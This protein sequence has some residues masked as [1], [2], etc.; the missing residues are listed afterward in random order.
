MVV[1]PRQVGPSRWYFFLAIPGVLIGFVLFSFFLHQGTRNIADRLSQVVVPGDA[2]FNFREL[3]TYTIFLEQPS[4]VKGKVYAATA[5]ADHLKCWVTKQPPSQTFVP[6][7]QTVVT[8]RRPSITLSYSFGDRAGRSVLEFQAD[9]AATYRLSCRYPEGESGPV[10]VLAVGRGVGMQILGTLYR[11]FL[12]LL[13]GVALAGIVVI[14]IH[15]KRDE[16]RRTAS[17]TYSE[18]GVGHQRHLRHLRNVV[19]TDD[20]RAI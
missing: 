4:E 2:T 10:V 11:T 3:G 1:Q 20:V 16:S 19:D 9:A 17:L 15:R 14:V 18:R 12:G 7:P 5:S 8:L 13:F 6:S